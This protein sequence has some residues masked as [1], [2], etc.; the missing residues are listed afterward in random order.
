MA[1]S[2]SR[3]SSCSSCS[4]C[5]I[6][7]CICS[8]PASTMARF[9]FRPSEADA[10]PRRACRCRSGSWA[11]TATG[12]WTGRAQEA[13]ENHRARESIRP[14]NETPRSRG[15]TRPTPRPLAAASPNRSRG[16]RTGAPPRGRTGRA[17]RDGAG[18]APR[19]GERKRG[20]RRKEIGELE[21][22]QAVPARDI[23]QGDQH[24]EEPSVERHA[25]VP[26]GESFERIGKVVCRLVEEH[27]AEPAAQN[28]AK[29]AK[30]QQIV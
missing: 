19:R 23:P 8:F 21:P 1:A 20:Q 6:C 25:A 27:V 4:R 22:A 26:D 10:K 24:A 30:K 29:H 15:G 7:A 13:Q 11:P 2:R 14:C 9:H 3:C 16:S 28:D 18:A 17:A 12:P 5:L